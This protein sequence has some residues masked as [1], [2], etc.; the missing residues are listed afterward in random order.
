MKMLTHTV[1]V[2]SYWSLWSIPHKDRHG[3]AAHEDDPSIHPDTMRSVRHFHNSAA[4]KRKRRHYSYQARVTARHRGLA[5]SWCRHDAD[6]E[7]FK[8]SPA[9]QSRQK[10]H[11]L[12]QKEP[13]ADRA[14]LSRQVYKLGVSAPDMRVR[15]NAN[16]G[17]TV[18]KT[19][20]RLTVRAQP[21][22]ITILAH[23]GRFLP[24][25]SCHLA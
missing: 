20:R 14:H 6:D 17:N 2:R 25:T 24:Q 9:A 19:G 13:Q 16:S 22:Q 11:K 18:L 23:V 12:L 7:T 8:T 1:V 4:S 10:K 21:P 5:P 15:L 3:C